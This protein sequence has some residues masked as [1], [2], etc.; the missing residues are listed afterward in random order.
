[1]SE[2]G[3]FDEAIVVD[4]SAA[5][6]PTT[7]ADSC[8][9]AMGPLSGPSRTK[10][11]NHPTRGAAVA[12]TDHQHLGTCGAADQ[13]A[14]RQTQCA[15]GGDTGDEAAPLHGWAFRGTAR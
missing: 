8:W 4:W 1:M 11:A 7:G 10:A 14:T 9:T 12:A 6:V 3:P 2:P 15:G 13:G 5:S